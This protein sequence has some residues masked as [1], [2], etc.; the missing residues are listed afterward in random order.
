MFK[1][2][3]NCTLVASIE[4]ITK[5]VNVYMHWSLLK[6]GRVNNER[7]GIRFSKAFGLGL[8]EAQGIIGPL[9][10]GP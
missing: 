6:R 4:R 3:D 10:N 8:V 2:K 5:F 9:K 1:G 7:V